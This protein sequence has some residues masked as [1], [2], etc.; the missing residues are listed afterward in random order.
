MQ[1]VHWQNLKNAVGLVLD[2]PL[3]SEISGNKGFKIALHNTINWGEAFTK[4]VIEWANLL[5]Q[6]TQKFFDLQAKRLQEKRI[7]N[8]ID[9]LHED[10][11]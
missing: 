2:D 5:L 6:T 10:V 8:I 4:S 3:I 9:D 11:G 7:Q 1:V